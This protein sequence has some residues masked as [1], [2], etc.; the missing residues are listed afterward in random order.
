MAEGRAADIGTGPSW[1]GQAL[2][3]TGDWKVRT[4]APFLLGLLMLF[5]SWDSIVIA[6]ALPV[7]IADWTLSPLAAGSLISAGYGGQL[8][9]AIFFG[10]V[11]ERYGRL[12]I[13]RWLVAIMSVLAGFCAIADSYNHLLVI[14]LVQGF[15]IGGALPI[16]ITYVN[17][18]APNA[19]RGR[20]FG[21]FQFLMIA[22]FGLASVVSALVVPDYGWRPVFAV[23]LIPLLILPFTFMLPESPRW[24]AARGR[25]ADAVKALARLGCGEG[26]ARP[27][28]DAANQPAEARVPFALLLAPGVRGEFV[29]MLLLWFLTYLVSFGLTTWMPS[30][31]VGVFKVPLKEAL[32][33]GFITST[34]MILVPLLLRQTIDRVGRRPPALIGTAL[35]GIALFG[36]PFLPISAVPMVA[37]LAITGA[38]GIAFGAMVLWPYSA[39]IFET[40]IRSL[41]LGTMSS[42]ARAASMLTPLL[43]GGILQATGSVTYIFLTFGAASVLAALIWIF[44]TRETAGREIA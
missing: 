36:I 17:E 10:S 3:G 2:D 7:I 21:N 5:D 40:R 25:I 43:V 18:V 35:G 16:A 6:Y 26:Q 15:A 27:G 11:A 42:T 44:L 9:G 1:V 32:S 8:V 31:Y 20:F 39:E 30:L 22:G 28:V 41:A 14:R 23:G 13:L 24:L 29:T 4:R 38:V 33:F 12:P 34:I 19:T 37:T